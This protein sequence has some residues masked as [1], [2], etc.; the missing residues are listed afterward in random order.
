MAR[1][2]H[3]DRKTMSNP[4][5]SRAVFSDVE[6]VDSE[7]EEDDG[8]L[9]IKIPCT[10]ESCTRMYTQ[11]GTRNRH[12]LLVHQK[13]PD[14]TEATTEEVAAASAKRKPKLGKST[15][16]T[17]ALVNK[18]TAHQEAV[19]GAKRKTLAAWADGEPSAVVRKETAESSVARAA[20]AKEAPQ[21]STASASSSGKKAD[22]RSHS[23]PST[24][25][26]H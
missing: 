26:S 14:G 23:Q 21:A 3:T 25:R 18:R 2:K 8:T 7:H 20:A 4:D 22:H 5:I 9:S 11:M 1:T 16:P 17:A 19:S 10:E 24:S 6:V 15:N 12:I 13:H